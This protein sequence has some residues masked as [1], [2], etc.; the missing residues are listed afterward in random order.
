MDIQD[1]L[2]KNPL[3]PVDMKPLNDWLVS[4]I[5]RKEQFEKIL[6]RDEDGK[7]STSF[8]KVFKYGTYLA[9]AR[10]FLEE[11]F[12]EQEEAFM[13]TFPDEEEEVA[14]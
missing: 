10:D 9:N 12:G 3:M 11:V 1:A 8:R 2:N 4:F 5:Q 6:I 7:L 13:R 14:P